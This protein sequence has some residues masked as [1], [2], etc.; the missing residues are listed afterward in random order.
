ME[1]SYLED[2]SLRMEKLDPF[3][4]G[5]IQHIPESADPSGCEHAMGRLFYSPANPN[6]SGAAEIADDWKQYVEPELQNLFE[7]ADKVVRDDIL[8]MQI[9]KNDEMPLFFL[10]I[11]HSHIQAWISTLNRARL[12]VAEVHRVTEEE[13]EAVLP[14]HFESRRDLALFQIYFYGILLDFFLNG[15]DSL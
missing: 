12:V 4:A 14:S 11:P 3:H 9:D 1:F 15:V 13:L 2:G 6:Q 7:S 5:L 10:A 8:A